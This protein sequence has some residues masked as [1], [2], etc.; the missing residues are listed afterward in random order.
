MSFTWP[1]NDSQFTL[2]NR[3]KLARFFLSDKNRWTQGERVKEFERA[4]AAYVGAKFAVFVSSG[5]TANTLLAMYTRDKL[6]QGR[7]TIVLPSVT[8]QTSCSP[9]IREGFEPHFIDVS[10]N[11]YAMNLDALEAY[12]RENHQ[13]VACVFITSLLGFVPDIQRL[14]DIQQKF[15]V[16]VMMDNCENSLGQYNVHDLFFENISS[17]FTSTTS[18]YFG[19]QL[20]SVEGGFIFTDSEEEYKYFVM[21]RNHGMTRSLQDLAFKTK[22]SNASYFNPD[23]DSRF[24]FN[25]LGNNFRNNDINAFIGLMDLERVQLYTERRV[26]FYNLFR[27]HLNSASYLLPFDRPHTMDV[28][29]CL[30]VVCIDA[31]ARRPALGLCTQLGI[32]TR[33][34]ISGNLLRQTSYRRFG[35]PDKFPNA[36]FLHNHG[37]YVGLYASLKENQVIELAHKLNQI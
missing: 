31:K 22:G 37:F 27:S 12:L 30:P 15:G 17:F 4:M 9:W 14:L 23:V 2:A 28:P 1:L 6:S 8:W 24:D 3:L 33:P 25:F 32:E 34:I 11:D 16:R 7:N 18:T 21:G 5:S 19:H 13:K 10:L 35:Q 36:E 20:Q 26:M 29:F